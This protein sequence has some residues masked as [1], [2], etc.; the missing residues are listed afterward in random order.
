MNKF[1]TNFA[2]VVERAEQIAL[3][4]WSALE[5]F[6]GGMIQNINQLSSNF[7]LARMKA[8]SAL[9][10]V[11]GVSSACSSGNTPNSPE[12][13]PAT[14]APVSQELPQEISQLP[15]GFGET[16][17]PEA[18]ATDTPA[19]TAEANTGNG[20]REF[21]TMP[22]K[23][24]SI[25]FGVES[26]IPAELSATVDTYKAAM[27][28]I[29]GEVADVC[30]IPSSDDLQPIFKSNGL[31]GNDYRWTVVFESKKN[32]ATCWSS[33]ASN[34]T[35]GDHPTYF[36]DVGGQIQVLSS[37]QGGGWE[38]M[39]EAVMGF[40]GTQPVALFADGYLQPQGLTLGG[41]YSEIVPYGTAPEVAQPS[42]SPFNAADM[43]AITN[44]GWKWENSTGTLNDP[45]N[46]E[47]LLY[48]DNV[49]YDG[50][51]NEME[52]SE[53]KF[54]S[55]NGV[56]EKGKPMKLILERTVNDEQGQHT[57]IFVQKTNEWRSTVGYEPGLTTET[58]RTKW[59][60]VTTEDVTSGF[61][62]ELKL[63]QQYKWQDGSVVPNWYISF[64]G[65]SKSGALRLTTESG[66]ASTEYKDKIFPTS[67][68]DM[69]WIQ[70][71]VD[72]T[73]N[74]AL[75]VSIHR[76]PDG[77]DYVFETAF[78][79]QQTNNYISSYLGV[80][81]ADLSFL[82]GEDNR[83]CANAS[84]IGGIDASSIKEACVFWP[85]DDKR[86]ELA[87]WET[88]LQG[89]DFGTRYTSSP[90]GSDYLAQYQDGVMIGLLGY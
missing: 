7:T 9:F 37:D 29:K 57:E 61:L 40:A 31:T 55:V 8:M 18:V 46:N 69:Y 65:G 16:P 77:I 71:P 32:R 39:D 56:D 21:F 15:V 90:L 43:E 25:E 84:L 67:P 19:P 10:L 13:P 6:A 47:I 86:W 44:A 52:V 45:N 73:K 89:D 74:I 30:V 75:G 14:E 27:N 4:A 2:E 41:M 88:I 59:H 17:G 51:G 22:E 48:Q 54:L 53:V 70:S 50:Q 60:V 58:D 12:L 36:K 64:V 26:P 38:R 11:L 20:P 42:E 87:T 82:V 76:G 72:P 66:D 85:K 63:A 3:Q 24:G 62:R 5:S 79:D 49:L 81:N 23:T 28:K 34:G 78:G 80:N 35:M 33:V 83:D 1:E 68:V